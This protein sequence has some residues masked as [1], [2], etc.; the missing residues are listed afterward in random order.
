M[1]ASVETDQGPQ[2]RYA[3]INNNVPILVM[4]FTGTDLIPAFR[5]SRNSINMLVQMLPRQIAHGWSKETEVLVT[6]YWLDCGAYR[7]TADIFCMPLATVCRTVHSVVEEMMAILHKAIHFPKPGEMEEV[8]AGFVRLAGHEAFRCAAGAI[9]GCHIWIL[10]PA[11]PKKKCYI[12][13]KL[14]PLSAAA[15]PMR[16]QG[17]I[18]GCVHRQ[19]RVCT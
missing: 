11:E 3:Q 13:R 4:F 1:K 10:P 9:D 12:N 2:K 19:S 15:G 7:V 14:F 5:L 16:R 17:H 18:L 8:G 6:V